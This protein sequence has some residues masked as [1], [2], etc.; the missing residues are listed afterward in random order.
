MLRIEFLSDVEK[1]A[2]SL[3]DSALPPRNDV[4]GFV[5]VRNLG[6]EARPEVLLRLDDSSGVDNNALL[7][8][9]EVA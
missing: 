8:L 1:G 3:L 2:Q 5:L 4:V 6:P 7:G 9:D